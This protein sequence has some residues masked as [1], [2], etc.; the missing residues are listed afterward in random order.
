MDEQTPSPQR[1]VLDPQ[2]LSAGLQPGVQYA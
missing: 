1:G 2:E